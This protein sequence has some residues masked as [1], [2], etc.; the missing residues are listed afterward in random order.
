MSKNSLAKQRKAAAVLS[1]VAQEELQNLLHLF[2]SDKSVV[3][4]ILQQY[5]C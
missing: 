3:N 5:F 2:G 4:K 1:G